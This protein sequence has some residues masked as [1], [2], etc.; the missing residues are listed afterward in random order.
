MITP[1]RDHTR[2]CLPMLTHP[3]HLSIRGR[4]SHQDTVVPILDLL[5]RERIVIRRHWNVATVE[6]GRPAVER[7][8]G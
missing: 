3:L 2:K 4:L 8:R 5:N 6:D 1:E 7:V